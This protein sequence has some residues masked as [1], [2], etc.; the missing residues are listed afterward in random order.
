MVS[1]ESARLSVGKGWHDLIDIAYDYIASNNINVL[2]VKEKFGQLRIYI[3]P[4]NRFTLGFISAI[5]NVS[6]TIC[7]ICGASGSI[8]SIHGWYKAVCDNC[9]RDLEEARSGN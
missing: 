2:Q 1:R 4:S 7:E 5:E 3:G 9:E 8:R 6:G